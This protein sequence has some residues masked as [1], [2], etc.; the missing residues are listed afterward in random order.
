MPVDASD[1]ALKLTLN[2]PNVANDAVDD[3]HSAASR[4]PRQH[5]AIGIEIASIDRSIM[6]LHRG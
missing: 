6:G 4:C 3:A 5:S 1:S 2:P